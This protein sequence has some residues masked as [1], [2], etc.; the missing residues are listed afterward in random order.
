MRIWIVPA[1]CLALVAGGINASGQEATV[2]NV[3][4]CESLVSLRILMAQAQPDSDPGSL[5]AHPDCAS[6]PRDRIGPVARRAIV[7]GA[8]HECMTVRDAERCV[9]IVP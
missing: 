9:W 6:I 2:G 5:A 7:G 3:I 8:P 4:G 1:A